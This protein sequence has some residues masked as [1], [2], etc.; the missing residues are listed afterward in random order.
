MN[1]EQL[2]AVLTNLPTRYLITSCEDLKASVSPSEDKEEDDSQG[3][4]IKRVEDQINSFEDLKLNEIKSLDKSLKA[5]K[6]PAI[7]LERLKK[8]FDDSH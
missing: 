2:L 5:I 4:S 3:F 7:L 6:I 1:F 8:E